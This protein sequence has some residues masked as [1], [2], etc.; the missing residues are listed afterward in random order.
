[1][2]ISIKIRD[3]FVDIEP[4]AIFQRLYIIKQSDK[5][6]NEHFKYEL[7]PYPTALFTEGAQRNEILVLLSFHSAPS[8][9]LK[10]SQHI[11]MVNEVIYCTR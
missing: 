4:L 6:L 3:K 9:H 7:T 5:K 2:S 1:M 10:R 8:K 11:F